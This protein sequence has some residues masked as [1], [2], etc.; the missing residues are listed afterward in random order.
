MFVL[1]YKYDEMLQMMKEAEKRET[2]WKKQE[3][4]KQSVEIV[5]KDDFQLFEEQQQLKIY[6][7]NVNN[8]ESWED[9]QKSNSHHNAEN[10]DNQ[11]DN[12]EEEEEQFRYQVD[13]EGFLV[14]EDGCYLEDESLILNYSGSENQT[15]WT[16]VGI[17]SQQ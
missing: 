16:A 9:H 1:N 5:V 17:S 13:E 11:E 7:K 3:S 8:L 10:A 14:D 15:C 12:S 2:D 6:D 4:R